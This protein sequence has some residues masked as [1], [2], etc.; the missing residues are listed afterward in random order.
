MEILIRMIESFLLYRFPA[1]Q[2][3]LPDAA[4]LSLIMNMVSFTLGWFCQ[5]DVPQ[6][7][8]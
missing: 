3:R 6:S 8:I 4:F 7:R 5:F 1:T 2:L